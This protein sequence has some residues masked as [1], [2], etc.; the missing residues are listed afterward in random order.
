MFQHLLGNNPVLGFQL[1]FWDCPSCEAPLLGCS[2]GAGLDSFKI[3]WKS[4]VSGWWTREDVTWALAED[5]LLSVKQGRNL[6][7]PRKETSAGI[8]VTRMFVLVGL[9]GEMWPHACIYQLPHLMTPP[10]DLIIDD[11][12]AYKS[13]ISKT[14]SDIGKLKT[15]QGLNL[16]AH[17]NSFTCARGDS[18]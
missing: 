4:W 12:T 10:V 15:P 16:V 3:G 5:N 18:E 1:W 13:A 14:V 7:R 9:L 11:E 6:P 8:F 2:T 17:S